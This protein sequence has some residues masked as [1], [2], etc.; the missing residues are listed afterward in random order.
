MD[1]ERGTGVGRSAFTLIELLVVMAIILVLAGMLTAAAFALK[2]MGMTKGAKADI[3]AIGVGLAAYRRDFG[4]YP[5]DFGMG[6]GGPDGVYGEMNETMVYYLGS[7]L[8][9]GLNTYGPYVQFKESKLTDEDNDGFHEYRDPY[10]N[11]YIYAENASQANPVGHNQKTYDL[12]SP[13]EDGL[14]GGTISKDTGYVD[15]TMEPFLAQERD[16]ISNWSN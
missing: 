11:L 15:A 1:R 6:A 7:K 5:P 3:Q 13:G 16:N 4:S 12:V 14:L 10:G 8:V 2:N 9:R